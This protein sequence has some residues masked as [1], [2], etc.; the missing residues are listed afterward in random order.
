MRIKPKTIT[1]DQNYKRKLRT[2]I[3]HLQTKI[4][5]FYLNIEFDGNI[6]KISDFTGLARNTIY[7]ILDD[8]EFIE[9]LMEMF[10][11]QQ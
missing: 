1:K 10:I 2:Q 4:Q 3:E 11:N 7:K 6:Q 9:D 5:V 8:E